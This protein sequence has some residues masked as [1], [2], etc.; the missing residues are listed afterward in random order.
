MPRRNASRELAQAFDRTRLGEVHWRHYM[1][2]S[3]LTYGGYA[4]E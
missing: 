4:P 2:A 1:R 3:M